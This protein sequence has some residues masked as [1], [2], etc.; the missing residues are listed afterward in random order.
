MSL[1]RYASV[2]LMSLRKMGRVMSLGGRFSVPQSIL[3]RAF[4]LVSFEVEI[5]D[6][7]ERFT[8]RLILSEHMQRRIFW[9]GFYNTDIVS[10]LKRK[11]CPGMNVIDVGANI[12]EIT[13]VSANC[14]GETGAVFAFEPV[15]LTADRLCHHVELNR[16]DRVHVRREA[17]A[18]RS[19]RVPIYKGAQGFLDHNDGL[20]SLYGE[21]EGEVPLEYVNVS[22]LDDV[23]ESLSL[24][25]VD[26]I[27]IDI[28]GGELPCLKGGESVIRRYRPM[29]IV[30]VQEFSAR[31]AGWELDELFSYLEGLGYE[32]FEIASK[33]SLRRL[34]IDS[35]LP[36][37]NVFCSF[38]G[39]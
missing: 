25:H 17:L 38:R 27:K 13:L 21:N 14:V 31:Q 39:S 33:G 1:V 12:G 6:F 26:L 10:V 16:L 28:E 4:R 32:F 37:Q 18:E 35:L 5:H 3:R 19:G 9:M 24:T 15:K 22:T 20:A 29:I 7:D 11:L 34:N 8:V 36:F 30:E 2:A 23:V